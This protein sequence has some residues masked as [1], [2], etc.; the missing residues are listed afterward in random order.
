VQAGAS[1]RCAACAALVFAQQPALG[2]QR[3]RPSPPCAGAQR[4]HVLPSRSA[5]PRHPGAQP[6]APSTPYSQRRL[7]PT[8]S[9]RPPTRGRGA[10]AQ[11]AVAWLN[12]RDVVPAL[13]RAHLHQRQYMDQVQKV[14]RILVQEA[15]LADAHLRLLWALTEKA[16]GPAPPRRPNPDLNPNPALLSAPA[17]VQCAAGRAAW[18]TRTCACSGR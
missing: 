17:R 14:L 4:A 12:E 13:L 5:A 8:L 9:R 1:C 6:A 2:E 16:R 3:A 15:G 18:P 10:R 11:A 7:T